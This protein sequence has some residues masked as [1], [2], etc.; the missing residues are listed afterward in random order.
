MVCTPQQLYSYLP[1]QSTIKCDIKSALINKCMLSIPL[2][3]TH[4]DII[5]LWLDFYIP[6]PAVVA[7]A[8]AVTADDT[9]FCTHYCRSS[10][11]MAWL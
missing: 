4:Y 2:Q 1:K 3:D 8:A 10:L 11:S 9:C 6:G 5:P 7:A